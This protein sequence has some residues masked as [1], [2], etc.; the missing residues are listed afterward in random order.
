VCPTVLSRVIP[1]CALSIERL[2]GDNCLIN[3]VEIE[4]LGLNGPAETLLHSTLTQRLQLGSDRVL[5][6]ASKIIAQFKSLHRKCNNFVKSW[7]LNVR[8]LNKS[9]AQICS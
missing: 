9:A 4:T 1:H 7:A 5:E 2:L 8:L 3:A 6:P